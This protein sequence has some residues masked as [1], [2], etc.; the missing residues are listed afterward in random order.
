MHARM[1]ASMCARMHASL[2]MRVFVRSC[3]CVWCACLSICGSHA[4]RSL[5]LQRPPKRDRNLP[6]MQACVRKW[7]RRLA[8]P[9]NLRFS[10]C[11]AEGLLLSFWVQRRPLDV[12]LAGA[13]SD[14]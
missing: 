2:C 11:G 6:S 1:H 3:A 5:T 7:R 13:S 4:R 14:A 9:A 12:Q 10:D 8:G